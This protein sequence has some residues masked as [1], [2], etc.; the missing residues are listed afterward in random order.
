MDQV[1]LN[2]NVEVCKSDGNGVNNNCICRAND[3]DY[4]AYY[5]VNYY[6]ANYMD[7]L[8]ENYVEGGDEAP[9]ESDAF[10]RKRRA[11]REVK[12]DLF[13]RIYY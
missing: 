2:C 5:Y 9:E 1:Y 10:E 6:Y 12:I 7:N 11:V 4:D 8:Y 3:I 13:T